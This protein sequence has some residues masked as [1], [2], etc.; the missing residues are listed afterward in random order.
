MTTVAGNDEKLS[1]CPRP[2]SPVPRP[3]PSPGAL[4]FSFS[5][6]S[7]TH[8]GACLQASSSRYL[9]EIA[10]TILWGFLQI[11]LVL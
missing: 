4:P 2:P 1:P 10:S 3:P 9:L 6:F 11:M 7:P 8:N 5:K